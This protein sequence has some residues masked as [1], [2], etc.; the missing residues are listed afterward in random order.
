MIQEKETIIR[1]ITALFPDVKIYLFGSYAR[2]EE[3]ETSDIDLAFDIGRKLTTK[4]L[5][6]VINIIEALNIPDKVDVVDMHSI[7]EDF[8][9]VILK[10]GVVWKD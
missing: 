7:P 9:N 5:S 1:L 6:R 2:G 8:K 4:E 10:E 3:R